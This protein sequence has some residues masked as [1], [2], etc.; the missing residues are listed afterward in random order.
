MQSWGCLEFI[1]EYEDAQVQALAP[2]H[3]NGFGIDLGK[4]QNFCGGIGR[5]ALEINN[6]VKKGLTL[7]NRHILGKLTEQSWRRPVAS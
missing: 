1:E 4:L 3:P 7:F 5:T 6:K 2:M